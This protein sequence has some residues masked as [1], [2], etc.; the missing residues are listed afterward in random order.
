MPLPQRDRANRKVFGFLIN[1]PL[2]VMCAHEHPHWKT[3]QSIISHI[4]QFSLWSFIFCSGQHSF[5]SL[6]RARSPPAAV[7]P[8]LSLSLSLSLWFVSCAG[9]EHFPKMIRSLGRVGDWWSCGRA[10]RACDCLNCGRILFW[11]QKFELICKAKI[12]RKKDVRVCVCASVSHTSNDS[13]QNN[14]PAS[15][16]LN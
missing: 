10:P 5:F 13:R 2:L 11:E 14:C 16:K 8:F 6:S 3:K 1:K 4:K 12:S 7:P 15:G 9:G